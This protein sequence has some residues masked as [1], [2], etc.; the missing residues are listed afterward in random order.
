MVFETKVGEEIVGSG[1][2]EL[3]AGMNPFCPVFQRPP[4]FGLALRKLIQKGQEFEA[5]LSC[6]AR[7]YHKS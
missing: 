3:G 6:V 4:R 5:R 7:L 2:G 1:G